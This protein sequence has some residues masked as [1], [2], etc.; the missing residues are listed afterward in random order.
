MELDPIAFIA[1]K[2][3]RFGSTGSRIPVLGACSVV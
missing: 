2:E 1:Y 3:E